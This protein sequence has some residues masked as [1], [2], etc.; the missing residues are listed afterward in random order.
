MICLVE[1][2]RAFK[3]AFGILFAKPKNWSIGC[4]ECIVALLAD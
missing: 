3:S 1:L 4:G 2:D